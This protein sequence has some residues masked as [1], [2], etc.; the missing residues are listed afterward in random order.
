MGKIDLVTVLEQNIQETIRVLAPK[1]EI[2]PD[3]LVG[4]RKPSYVVGE[5]NDEAVVILGPHSKTKARY[6]YKEIQFE[7][8]P[9]SVGNL[10]TLGHEVTHYLHHEFSPELQKR[11]DEIGPKKIEYWRGIELEELLGCYGGIVYSTTKGETFSP[12]SPWNFIDSGVPG[13]D[14]LLLDRATDRGYRRANEAVMKYGE[15]LLPQLIRMNLEETE[16]LPRILPLNFF[17]RRILK[18]LDGIKKK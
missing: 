18:I 2:T 12:R 5:V 10:D 7:F 13:A 16:Q 8:S 1:F 9:E 6:H 4:F 3:I 15:E 17:E 14:Y 11:M